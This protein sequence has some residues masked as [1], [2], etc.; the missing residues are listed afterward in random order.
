MDEIET[1]PVKNTETTPDVSVNQEKFIKWVNEQMEQMKKNLTLGKD[2]RE[3]TFFELNQALRSWT[4]V[5]WSLISLYSI[6]KIEHE[7]K[8]EE[9][10]NW[11]ADVFIGVRARENKKDLSAGKWASQ[12]EIEMMVR[13]EYGFEFQ[14]RKADLLYAERQVAYLRRIL[15]SWQTHQF[16][17]GTLSRN[18][19][20]EASA[21]GLEKGWESPKY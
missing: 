12:K 11:Y 8:N 5:H 18:M 16:V 21:L 4:E 9:F 6:A 14:G 2:E 15:E 13:K 19:Q 1:R 17:L 7:A 20:A 10:E 3:I